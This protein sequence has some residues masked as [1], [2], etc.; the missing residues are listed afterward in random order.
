MHRITQHLTCSRA[1][2]VLLVLVLA[3]GLTATTTSAG[4]YG[5]RL[6][7]GSFEEG[8]DGNGVGA[9]WVG[10]NNGGAA[11]YHFQDDVSPAFNYDGKH[12][13]LIEVSTMNNFVTD[14]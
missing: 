7:N 14:P 8:F 5:E 12:S 3:M 6:S 13:Q 11:F 2:F 1:L 10:F 9:N 4:G